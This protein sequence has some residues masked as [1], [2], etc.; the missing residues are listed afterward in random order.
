MFDIGGIVA[1]S[2]KSFANSVEEFVHHQTKKPTDGR[3]RYT[4]LVEEYDRLIRAID[5][6]S[7]S[8]EGYEKWGKRTF[9]RPA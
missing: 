5:L 3:P 4:I 8:S 6:W 1:D 9:S 7:E 2:M